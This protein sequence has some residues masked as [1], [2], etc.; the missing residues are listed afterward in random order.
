MLDLRELTP[1]NQRLIC[2]AATR[3]ARRGA[4]GYPEW[5]AG[6]LSDLSDMVTRFERGEP[7]LSRSDWA[8]VVPQEG[9]KI[10]PGWTDA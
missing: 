4:G 8:E 9:R 10:G 7:P 1:G 6:C 2:E 3:A 5:L